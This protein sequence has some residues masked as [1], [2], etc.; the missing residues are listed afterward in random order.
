MGAPETN[1]LAVFQWRNF[2]FTWLCNSET[3]RAYDS[4]QRSEKSGDSRAQ[5]RR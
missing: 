3:F 5:R 1:V 2:S 4:S